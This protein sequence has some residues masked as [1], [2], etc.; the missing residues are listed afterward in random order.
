[1]E[2]IVQARHGLQDDG[3][4][5]GQDQ[6]RDA[7]I[8]HLSGRIARGLSKQDLIGPDLDGR[9]AGV[10]GEM[11]MAGHLDDILRGFTPLR[12]LTACPLEQ[13]GGVDEMK[14]EPRPPGARARPQNDGTELVESQFDAPIIGEGAIP[15]GQELPQIEIVVFQ[16]LDDAGRLE[17]V[18]FWPALAARSPIGD[19]SQEAG[20][21]FIKGVAF[22]DGLAIGV[23]GIHQ[24]G[25]LKM[26]G[27]ALCRLK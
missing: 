18:E 24:I 20:E 26:F 25:D 16:C 17:K 27:A 1:M 12:V 8:H 3:H 11:S 10:G 2:L 14:G 15:T 7:H 21:I 5:A 23:N 9:G 13:I 6:E 22:L 4:D 19:D